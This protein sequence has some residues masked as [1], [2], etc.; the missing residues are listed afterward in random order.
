VKVAA[1]WDFP[2]HEA[3]V[4]HARRHKIDL[5]VAECHAGRRTTPW[6][7]H[8]TDWELLRTSPVPVLLVKTG[9]SWQDLKVLADSIGGPCTRSW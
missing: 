2:A 9:A 8:L 1:D 3:I 5:I 4:R 7:L 6:L